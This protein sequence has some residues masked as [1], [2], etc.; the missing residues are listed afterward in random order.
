MKGC[1]FRALL[2]LVEFAA[3]GGAIAVALQRWYGIAPGDAI[4]ALIFASLFGWMSVNLI[5]SA[6]TAWRERSA[7]RAGIA[8]GEP[9][10]GRRTI[11]VGQIEPAGSSI[12]APLSDRECVAYTF[13][14]YEM[15]RVGKSSSKVLYA[16]GIAL[17]P[18]V[19]ITRGGSYRLLAVPE[20][21]C[22]DTDLDNEAARARAVEQMSTLTYEPPPAPFTRPSI[23]Q[24]WNDDDG[25]Y[26]RETRHVEDD[27]DLTRCRLSEKCLERGA[28]VC[29]FG[30]Y[31]AAKRAIVADRSDWSKITRVM[32]GDAD[33]VARQLGGSVVRRLIGAVL[34]AAAAV[35]TLAAFVSSLA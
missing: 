13:E 11:L 16:D 22:P 32:K 24:Q 21:D 9:V 15:K 6:I 27:V 35:G 25:A 14:I 20:L 23:E 28:R 26:R 19:I 3:I 8:G 18:S 34:S 30:Q 12:R 7:L 17:T 4:G 1:A 29:V 5:R 31:S 33:V 10:D 2:S